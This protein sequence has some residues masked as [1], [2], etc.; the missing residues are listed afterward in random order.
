MSAIRRHLLVATVVL[1][2]VIAPA[3]AHAQGGLLLQGVVDLEQWSTDTLSS[4]LSRN[5]G[6][7]AQLARLQLWGA[8]E[9]KQGVFLFAQGMMETGD[10]RP[11]DDHRTLTELRQIGMRVTRDK[12]FVL[13]VGKMFHPIGTFAPRSLSTRNPLIGS[14]DGY[15]PIYPVGA[16]LSGE[17]RRIDYRVAMVTLPLTHRDYVPTAAASPRPVVGVGITPFI[18]VH[19]GVSATAGPYLNEYVATAALYGGSWDYYRQRQVA[20]DLE[21]GVGH[22]DVRAE[23]AWADY[24][25]PAQ[26]R[27]G[28]HTGYV[29]AQYTLTPRLFAAVRGE[30]TV[31]PFLRPGTPWIR[32]EYAF[33]DW[34]TGL[35]LR[36]TET[37]LLKASYMWDHW[38]ERA[39][40]NR[41]GGSGLAFQLSQSFDVMDWLDSRR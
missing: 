36:V 38:V 22:L 1:A 18:G 41:P 29:E 15:S 9:P 32:R 4:F 19:V 10:A 21:Y 7:A 33:R 16:M 31:Y 30:D 17:V 27:A 6:A 8:F 3:S 23:R 20:A 24:E 35:G 5:R 2:G 37:T 13:N 39:S 40:A 28:G 34:E 12:R 26:S 14:P 25:V 11:Y